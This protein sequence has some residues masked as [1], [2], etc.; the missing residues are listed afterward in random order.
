MNQ[1]LLCIQ[2]A[3]IGDLILTTPALQALRVQFPAAHITILTSPH[4]A[5][6]LD[7]S[8]LVDEVITAPRNL[9]RSRTDLGGLLRLLRR[10]RGYDTILIFH[11][12]TTRIG[13]WKYALLAFASGARVR[14][15]LENGRGWFLTHR[16][17]DHGFGV[18]HQADYWLDVAALIGATGGDR[19]LHVGIGEADRTWAAQQLP[20]SRAHYIAIHPGSGGFSLARRWEAEKFVALANRL[21]ADRRIILVGGKN[22]G[23]DAISAQ[24]A[25]PAINLAGKTTLNQLTAIL[26]RCADFYGADSGVMHLAAAAG[27]RIHAIYGP[28]NHLAWQPRSADA[29]VIRSGVLCSPCNYTGHTLGLRHGCEARTCMKLVGVDD[30]LT[31]ENPELKLRADIVVPT[32]SRGNTASARSFSS[33]YNGSESRLPVLGIPIDATTF[34]ALLDQI[35]VWMH[36]DSAHQICT[37]NPEYVIQAQRDVLLFNILQRSDLNVPD[38]VGLLWAAKRL[39]NPLPQRV[40]GSDGISLIAERAAQEGWRLFLLGAAPG[41]ADRVAALW[42]ERYPNIQIAGTYSGDASAEQEDHIAAMIKDCHAD[43]LFVA[44]GQGKQDHWIARNLPRL[45]VKAALGVGGAFDFVAGVAVRAPLWMQRLGVEWLHRLIT[46]PWR[47]R[48]MLRL[49]LFVIAVLTRGSKPPR[50]FEG[51]KP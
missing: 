50:A 24:L 22:D 14:A 1:R 33:G 21:P 38:G 49:P 43:V 44:F 29:Q 51:G 23:A 35:S 46:Q 36:T 9:I 28:S 8:G 5:P 16:A 18:K 19:K 40:T 11:Q 41:V 4:A 39:G 10:S 20:D 7:H 12:L 47:W 48:R 42:R 30:V 2:L 3:D 45:G 34:D 15:G 13:A 27:T 17:P 31:P 32:D 37:V 26:E 25:R 6:M